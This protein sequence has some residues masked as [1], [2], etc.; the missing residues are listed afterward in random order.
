M[1][2]VA[3]RAKYQTED[4]ICDGYVCID[5]DCIEGVFA[6][7]YIKINIGKNS[8]TLFLYENLYSIENDLVFYATRSRTFVSQNMYSSSL[9]CPETYILFSQNYGMSLSLIETIKDSEEVEKIFK[10]LS[11]IRP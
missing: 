7:D 1:E 10:D 6:R 11:E 3:I 2:K 9:Y 4:I 5:G 8:M